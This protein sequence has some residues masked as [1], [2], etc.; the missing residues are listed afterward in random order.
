MN[1]AIKQLLDTLNAAI[2]DGV[3]NLPTVAEYILDEL[4][5]YYIA[6]AVTRGVMFLSALVTCIVCCTMMIR[7]VK[8]DASEFVPFVFGAMGLITGTAAACMFGFFLSSIPRIVSPLSAIIV[9][10]FRH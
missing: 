2:K 9:E 4:Q 7:E 5:R 1:G 8:R 6:E 3:A 10:R